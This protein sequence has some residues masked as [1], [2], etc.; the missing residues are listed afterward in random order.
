MVETT[1]KQRSRE[2]T[3][4]NYR[5]LRYAALCVGYNQTN[6]SIDLRI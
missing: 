3:P 4:L 6:A 1:T 5:A 2:E